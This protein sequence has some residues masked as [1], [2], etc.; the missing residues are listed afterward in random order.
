MNFIL[1]SSHHQYH[2][3][4]HHSHVMTISGSL[5][6]HITTTSSHHHS[7]CR[8]SSKDLVWASSRVFW[9]PIRKTTSRSTPV[10]ESGSGSLIEGK[11]PWFLLA[12]S[13]G[14]TLNC[15]KEDYW[16]SYEWSDKGRRLARRGLAWLFGTS[17]SAS[18]MNHHTT[19]WV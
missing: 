10:L 13:R 5:I 1:T 7:T 15:Y 8:P 12:W 14:N 17:M 11:C 2:Y 6:H 18:T 4:R 16:G 19:Q 9:R 3:P